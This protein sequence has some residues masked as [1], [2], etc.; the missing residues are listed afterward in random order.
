ML[1]RAARSP[2]R[3]R[4]LACIWRSRCLADGKFS[5]AIELLEEP[6]SGP[7]SLVEGGSEATQRP[8]FA[9]EVYKAALRAYL[10]DDAAEAKKAVDV[11]RAFGS[12]GVQAR[13]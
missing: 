11:A 10:I 8:E 7:L 1:A 13:R 12:G 6:K 5:E 9:V 4:P 3:Q 2:S